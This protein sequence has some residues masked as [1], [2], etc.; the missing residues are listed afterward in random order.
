MGFISTGAENMG[1]QLLGTVATV[2][3]CRT[4]Y[5]QE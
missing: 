1:P 2:E 4:I 3:L 5:I